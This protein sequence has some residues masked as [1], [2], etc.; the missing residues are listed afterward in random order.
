MSLHELDAFLANVYAHGAHKAIISE[1]MA[2]NRIIEIMRFLRF[3]Y[4]QT[5]SHRLAINKLALISTVW[6]TFVGICLRHYKPGA[7]ITIHSK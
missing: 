5:Q 4:K 1:T 7:N 2:L 3:H 6:Y